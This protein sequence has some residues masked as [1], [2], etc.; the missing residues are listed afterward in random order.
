MVFGE[1][2]AMRTFNHPGEETFFYFLGNHMNISYRKLRSIDSEKY[3]EIR[4]E[5]LKLHPESFG[6]GYEEQSV[7]PK[8]KF[9]KS[10]E[11]PIDDRFVLGAFDDRGLIGICAFGCA[12]FC[13]LMA[14]VVESHNRDMARRRKDIDCRRKALNKRTST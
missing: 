4:L 3:R 1:W 13:V 9:E 2:S 5:S 10:L 7:L 12:G 8:L 11:E 14:P 6:S